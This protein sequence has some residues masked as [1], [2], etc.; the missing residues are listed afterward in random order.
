MALWNTSPPAAD[1]RSKQ[2][3]YEWRAWAQRTNHQPYPYSIQDVIH[4]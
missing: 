4:P 2:R 3:P 1:G